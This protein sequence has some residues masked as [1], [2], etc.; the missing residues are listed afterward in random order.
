[1][2]KDLL[3]RNKSIFMMGLF[4]CVVFLIVIGF[5]SL[6]E[7]Q[8]PA[9]VKVTQ[10]Q[11]ESMLSTEREI[12]I[13]AVV[14][15]DEEKKNSDTAVKPENLE[16]KYTSSGFIPRDSKALLN[17]KVKW[18]NTTGNSIFLQQKTQKYAELEQPVEIKPGES[19]ELT[20]TQ[21]NF[22]TFEEVDTKSFGS[23]MVYKE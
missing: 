11:N 15:K 8:E 20:L 17:Q 10:E 7:T 21:P 3:V 16:I 19:F 13:P 18:V 14:Q 12:E 2:I 4:T 1:M 9:L 22:F 5:S 6:K 23:I